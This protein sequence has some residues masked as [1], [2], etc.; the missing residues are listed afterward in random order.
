MDGDTLPGEARRCSAPVAAALLLAAS[1][2][3]AANAWVKLTASPGLSPGGSRPATVG[4]PLPRGRVPLLAQLR[5]LDRT[6]AAVPAQFETLA[7]WPDGSLR[8]V[9]ADFAATT[10]VNENYRLTQDPFT[11]AP[12]PL[13][14]VVVTADAASYTIDTGA[15]RFVVPR[16]GGF[17]PLVSARAGA[18]ELLAAP[19][20]DLVLSSG[21]V[22]WRSSLDT[23]A[24]VTLEQA[25]PLRAVLRADGTFRDAASAALLA[26]RTRLH[27]FAGERRVRVELT[28]RNEEAAVHPGNVWDLGSPGSRDVEDLSL[29]LPLPPAGVT[30]WT[31][32]GEGPAASGA[33]GADVV[34]YQ[35][36]SGGARWNW[37][38][39]VNRSNVVP[40]TLRGFELREGGVPRSAGLRAAGMMD[41]SGPSGGVAAG[42]PYFWQEFPKALRARASGLEV[43]L[44]PAEFPDVHELQGGEEKTTEVWL[45]FHEGSAAAAQVEP[46]LAAA[47]EREPVHVDPV[48]YD[49]T[50]AAGL[51]G[52]RGCATCGP[53]RDTVTY[54]AYDQGVR[55]FFTQREEI[56]EYG[57]RNFGEAFSDHETDC[58]TQCWDC[59]VS[60]DNN[61]YD[62]AW[63]ALAQWACSRSPNSDRWFRLGDEAVRHHRDI[64]VYHTD[65]DTPA[66]NRGLFWHTTHDTNAF[67]STH[68]TYSSLMSA[69]CTPYLSGGPA[70]GHLYT[71]GLQLHGYMTGDR[72]SFEVHDEL[73]GFL[74][75]RY[76]LDA[77]APGSGYEPRA[78]ANGLRT[79]VE[80]CRHGGRACALADRIVADSDSL[81]NPSMDGTSFQDS[82]LMVSLGRYLDMKAERGERLD[83]PGSRAFES[84]AELARRVLANRPPA[85][86]VLDFRYSEGLWYAYLH[87]P[88][89]DPRR[90]GFAQGGRD[91]FDAGQQSA[92]FNTY[93]TKKGLGHLA[94]NGRLHQYFEGAPVPAPLLTLR[95]AKDPTDPASRLL[96]SWQPV[97]EDVHGHPIACTYRV[98]TSFD[99][100]TRFEFEPTRV[101]FGTSE[102]VD[103]PEPLTFLDVRAA[104]ELE[105]E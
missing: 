26:H 12:A 70:L 51:F 80:A 65:R 76:A 42:L 86:D 73:V 78:W 24:V 97:T 49:T 5:I 39:H 1:E 91:M 54:M 41:L 15:A 38:T 2:A 105:G 56:D 88:A 11:P 22:A 59:P 95:V 4:V 53:W 64:D 7:T 71:E 47:L 63:S 84:L 28:L 100:P 102:V 10:S 66:Y 77:P 75:A 72:R 57:W 89:G 48:A 37:P 33:L 13:R 14:P 30:T 83:V 17:R 68:R 18:L 46:S 74:E 69:A 27:F 93:I 87:A 82:M 23:A 96:L 29:V 31:A 40:M 19:G 92:F 58:G 34:L 67:T 8:F 61:Q 44:L 20:A 81:L 103:A 32:W 43:A 21:G 52:V 45:D 94:S 101:T 35:E 25:G 99:R 85:R 55:S 9:L 104:D 98:R 50:R 3:L 6:G 60:H 90:P 62:T 16:A 79:A 36:S